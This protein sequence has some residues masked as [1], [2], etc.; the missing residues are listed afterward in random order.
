LVSSIPVASHLVERINLDFEVQN[1]IVPSMRSMPKF[2]VYGRLPNVQIKLSD[3]KYQSLMRVID[4]AIPRLSNAEATPT[5]TGTE[6]NF[7]KHHPLFSRTEVEYDLVE[8]HRPRVNDE[9][10]EEYAPLSSEV[11]SDSSQSTYKL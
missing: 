9:E 2:K 7:A 3:A 11:S 8:D 1:S 10:A 4:S 5:L 6:P